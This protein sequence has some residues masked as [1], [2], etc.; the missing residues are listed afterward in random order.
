[1]FK[2][3]PGPNRSRIQ[4]PIVGVLTNS[5]LTINRDPH[6]SSRVATINRDLHK[7]TTNNNS[8]FTFS[9]SLKA[10]EEDAVHRTVDAVQQ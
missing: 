9:S 1:M 6:L 10:V 2:W 7:V 8:L 4:L 3:E 5:S